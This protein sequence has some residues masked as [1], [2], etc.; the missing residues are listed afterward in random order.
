MPQESLPF[1]Q[2][3]PEKRM[4]RNFLD[5]QSIFEFEAEWS[6]GD[7]V[8]D[9]VSVIMRSNDLFHSSTIYRN[10]VI[11]II[12]RQWM[13]QHLIS[14]ITSLAILLRFTLLKKVFTLLFLLLKEKCFIDSGYSNLQVM[15]DLFYPNSLIIHIS[16]FY[17]ESKQMLIKKEEF[18]SLKSRSLRSAV[19]AAHWPCVY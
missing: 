14:F 12:R 3:I 15:Y 18:I 13:W 9:F 4:F 5:M 11:L 16:H 17:I 8:D 2:C 1:L 19:V 6:G 10:M 7:C